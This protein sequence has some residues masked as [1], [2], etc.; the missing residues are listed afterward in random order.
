[1]CCVVVSACVQSVR[2]HGVCRGRVAVEGQEHWAEIQAHSAEIQVSSDTCISCT[3]K[4]YK[5]A[6]VRVLSVRKL[7][8]LHCARHLTL[9]QREL[10]TL[11]L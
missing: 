4:K 6:R 11:A 9:L 7:R 2:V 1:M 5:S 3:C 10:A 8:L